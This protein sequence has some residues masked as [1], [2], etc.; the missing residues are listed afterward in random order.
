[1][2]AETPLHMAAQSGSVDC[3]ELLLQHGA[4]IEARRV[5]VER[6][7]VAAGNGQLLAVKCLLEKGARATATDNE[8]G[9]RCTTRAFKGHVKCGALFIRK[10]PGHRQL[11]NVRREWSWTPLHMAAQSGSVDCIELLLQHGA[12]I[13]ATTSDGK[14]RCMLPLPMDSCSLCSVC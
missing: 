14:R 4:N 9:C 7:H 1:M 5:T 6:L 3:I 13:E 8:G 10:A 11:H 2:V 12:N